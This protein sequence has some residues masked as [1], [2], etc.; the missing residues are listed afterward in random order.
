MKRYG[1][2]PDLMQAGRCG[3]RDVPAGTRNTCREPSPE[4]MAAG[5][6]HAI[7]FLRKLPSLTKQP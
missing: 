5:G 1:D 6:A 3:Q 7:G 2:V 4:I